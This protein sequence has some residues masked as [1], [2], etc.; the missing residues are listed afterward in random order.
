MR[1]RSHTPAERGQS[2]TAPE[3]A[4]GSW[5]NPQDRWYEGDKALV[6]SYAVWTLN[7]CDQVMKKK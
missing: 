5:S 6:T 1:R 7:I 3:A 4:P 2:S